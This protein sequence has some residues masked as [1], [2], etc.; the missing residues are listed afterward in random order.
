M[1][2][3]TILRPR[4]HRVRRAG[5]LALLCGATTLT[6]LAGAEA[7]AAHTLED[8]SISAVQLAAVTLEPGG[9]AWWETTNLS[10]GTDTVLHLWD[11]SAQTE[12]AIDHNG[13]DGLASKLE[14]KNTS[15]VT[16]QYILVVRAFDVFGE[17]TADL[18]QN[19]SLWLSKIPVAGDRVVPD[20]GPGYRYETAKPPN[21][22]EY[23]FL[24]A[25]DS[26][27][28]IVDLD[29]SS[30]VGN[31]ARVDHPST[32]SILIGSFEGPTTVDLYANDPDDK[33]G[34]G[35][36]SALEA[37]LGTCDS[38]ASPGCASVF[39]LRDTDRDGLPDAAEVFGID[40]ASD[41]QHLPAWGADPLHKDVFV[42]VDFHEGLG[43]QPLSENDAVFLQQMF[44]SGGPADDVLNPDGLGGINLHLDLGITPSMSANAT[45][46]GDWGGSNEVPD[47]VGYPEAPADHRAPV[48]AGIFRYALLDGGAGGQAGSIP[49]DRFGAGIGGNNLGV[50]AHELGHTLGLHHFGH[51]QWGA[52]NGKPNYVSVMNYAFSS[53]S[54][55]T[56]GNKLVLNP[57]LVNELRGNGGDASVVGPGSD[58]GRLISGNAVD[59]D[60]DLQFSDGGFASVRAPLT[61]TGWSSDGALSQNEETLHFDLGLPG[62]TPALVKG[63]GE[64]LYAFYIADDRIW[65]QF[66]AVDGNSWEGS[67]PGGDEIGDQCATWSVRHEVPTFADAR[68]VTAVFEDGKLLLAFRTQ[69]DSVRTIHTGAIGPDGTVGTWVHEQ[70]HLAFTDKEPEAHLMRVDPEKFGEEAMVVAL[71]YVDKSLG[72]YR[73]RTMADIDSFGSTDQGEMLD[74]F[75][76]KILGLQSPTFANWP[77]NP[78]TVGNGTACGA[79]T[80]WAKQVQFHCYN[81][82][83]DRFEKL[84]S[85]AFASDDNP[86]TSGKPGLIFHAYRSWAGLPKSGQA[87]RGAFWLTVVPPKLGS[88]FVDLRV[89]DPISTAPTEAL[90]NV[91]FDRARLGKVG[92]EW[93]NVADGSGLALYD[94]AEM[95]ALK[96][97]WIRQDDGDAPSDPN[98]TKVRFLPFVDG[99]F[100]ASLRDGSDYQLMERDICRG[101]AGSG[102][103]GPS[104]FG[105]D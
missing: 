93:T 40:D 76:H 99:T 55:S 74:Q 100:R 77:N 68:G 102:F 30:G 50:F 71:M 23:P 47:S 4:R 53:A 72:T 63:P 66:A 37:E 14:F 59:W 101:L 104:S 18:H 91:F 28:R 54:F 85:T 20:S 13:G 17:G 73:W 49:G 22:A 89:S 1:R 36:G 65:Y 16:R 105:L 86:R 12:V 42:E 70:F 98:T 26:G 61:Y 58:Y 57:V 84:T 24:I 25:F 78:M 92:N 2:T 33:D 69:W 27:S 3:T 29:F 80:N 38:I 32:V 8:V 31:Q 52:V 79:M 82:A 7:Q 35:L 9:S 88:D 97:L 11:L 45:I 41:P 21:G 96:G 43:D 51:P 103:C 5:R 48:R 19:G 81:R 15:S 56:G 46:L 60:F 6:A 87:H 83:T 62:T 34:D 10:P 67:C 90:G 44:F 94:D 39:N 75:G 64:R 95:G